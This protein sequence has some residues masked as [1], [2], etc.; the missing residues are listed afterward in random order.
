MNMDQASSRFERRL[1]TNLAGDLPWLES[2][3]RSLGGGYTLRLHRILRPDADRCPHDHPYWMVRLIVKGGYIEECG[4]ERRV[5]HR[6]PG[7]ITLHPPLF[8]HRILELLDRESWSLVITGPHERQWGFYTAQGWMSCAD[9]VQAATQ[10][11]LWCD[12][13]TQ[14]LPSAGLVNA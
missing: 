9:F 7:D 14:L 1:I 3:E 12:D 8:Q 11:V 6:R 13:G 2:L 10:G 4:P 5:E